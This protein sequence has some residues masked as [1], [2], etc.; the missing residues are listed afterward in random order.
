MDPLG[1]LAP[2]LFKDTM[3]KENSK[4]SLDVKLSIGLL[5]TNRQSILGLQLVSN[6]DFSSTYILQL[7]TLPS[8]HPSTHD[9]I[10]TFGWIRDWM[11]TII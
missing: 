9:G 10:S 4:C 1:H 5:L 3:E 2:W 11:L 8:N 6:L 7:L